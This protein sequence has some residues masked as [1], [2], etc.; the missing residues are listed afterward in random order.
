M[1]SHFKWYPAAED[2]VV[3][4]NARYSYPSQANKAQKM[5]PRLPPKNGAIFNPGTVIRLEFPAQG[6]VNPLNTTLE[7]DVEL[8][9]DGTA[10][11]NL[12]IQNNI[13]SLFSRV[14]LLYGATPIEDIIN[15]NQIVRSLTEWTGTNQMN[16]ADQTTIADGVGGTFAAGGTLSNTR[17]ILIQGIVSS[18]GPVVSNTPNSYNGVPR[19]RYQINLALGMFTQDKLIPTKFMASQLAI[20]ITLENAVACLYSPFVALAATTFPSY[21]VKNVNL[22]PEILEFDASYD[23]MF[24]KGL[25]DGGVPIKFSSWHTFLFN[26]GTSNVNLLVQERS[27]SVKALF[28]MQRRVPPSFQTDS[29]ATFFVTNTD[30]TT[31]GATTLT[32]GTL[33]NFQFR[34]GGRYY[35]AAPIQCSVDTGSAIT[36]GAAEAYIELAKALNIVGDYR[37]SSS[38]NV[39]RWGIAPNSLSG[40]NGVGTALSTQLISNLMEFD[41]DAVFGGY[42]TVGGNGN[43]KA[44]RAFTAATGNGGNIGSNCF[45]MAISLETTNG[46]EI[47]GLNAEEQ[48][49]IAVIAQWSVAQAS[50]FSLEVYSYYDA[51]IILKENNVLELIQ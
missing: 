30:S 3:P 37:L 23:Q 16:S 38:C 40:G 51:M 45:A 18:T 50:N 5:T 1:A 14:R 25:Q 10:L 36:N 20:E 7:F 19:R 39:L 17:A 15:Y 49:D 33:Q 47:S 13:Q 6:Y 42:D 44:N 4:W 41:Y 28:V 26:A 48:S 11:Q 24:L 32:G 29:G 8:I 43:I 9:G 27:R 35:P 34:I 31:P 12:R 22:L 21:V 46:V 2:V